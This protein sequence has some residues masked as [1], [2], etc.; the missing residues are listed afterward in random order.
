MWKVVSDG[1]SREVILTRRW[2]LKFPKVRYGWRYFLFGLLANMSEIRMWKTCPEEWRT[3][4]CPINLSIPGGFLV[5]MPRCAA[6]GKISTMD[7]QKIS[8]QGM[9]PIEFKEDSFGRMMDGSLVA[10]DYGVFYK[11]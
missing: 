10:V 9:I 3:S 1:I 5:I 7:H 6:P 11:C 8:K 4:L 2:A